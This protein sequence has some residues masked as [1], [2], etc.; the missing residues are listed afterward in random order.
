MT[1]IPRKGGTISWACAPGFPPAVIFPLV[2]PGRFGARSLYE[3][4]MLMYRPL[5]WYGTQ[6][7]AQ[8]DYELSMAEAP[9]WSEDGRTATLTV[10]PYKWSNG[11]TVNAD[12]VMLWMHLLEA[13]KEEYGGYAPGYF[14]DNLTGYEKVA[15]DQVRFTFDG[16]YAQNWVLMNQFSL[17]TPLPKA[18]DRTAE[19]PA[20]ATVDKDEAC[21]V[22]D[23]LMAE[24]GDVYA[25][26]NSA[27]AHWADSPIWS[28]VNG[29]W[30]LASYAADGVVTMV[31]NPSYSG[32]NK[33][34]ADAFRLVPTETDEEQYR[35]LEGGPHGPDAIHLGFLPFDK[36]TEPAADPVTGGPNPLAEH[37]RIV[38]QIL[39]AIHYFPFN[40]ANTTVSG[41]IFRQLYFRQALQT[42]LD[43]DSSFQEI[44]QGYG[45]PT[46]GPVP[47]LPATELRSPAQKSN[48][49]PFDVD[50]ARRMLQDNGWDTS[51]TPA[52]CVDPGT[53]PGQAGEG[54]PAGTRLTVSL[55]YAAGHEKT[56]TRVMR[57]FRDDAARAGIELVL[58]E[59]HPSVLV[60]Q[61]TTG[62]TSW[63]LSC[64]N[65]GW[66]YGPN[67]HPTGELLYQTGAGCNFGSY[68]D[69]VADELIAKTVTSDD[70]A[71]MYAYQDYLAEQVPVIWMPNF[72]LRVFEVAN[73]LKGVEPINPL[74]F[75]NPENWYFVDE[76][77]DSDATD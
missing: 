48:P 4:Q 56:L 32:P 21:A 46:Y 13:K 45:Y 18:W 43:Q 28:I 20:N 65:G 7:D 14:P 49:F 6:G 40:F 33:P 64:W 1:P 30:K 27:R 74:G 51:V 25:E 54:I 11:E 29:P 38:P 23:Y 63:E 41:K 52:V 15:E 68:S 44:Y 73:Q 58:E 24:N 10:K 76:P 35:A 17:I 77:D 60:G 5:Y 31:P 42:T 57:K 9:R 61:D 47:A 3:F 66:V 26:E 72:P 22:Y 59:V 53:G 37:Y 36:I 71:D 19:G 2:P 75:I 70:L 67:F 8:V 62:A 39:Y 34:Y 50:R 69:P 12:G 55:R 16:A